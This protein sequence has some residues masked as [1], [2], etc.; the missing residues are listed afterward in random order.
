[1]ELNKEM[2]KVMLE[3]EELIGS[4]C[5]NPNSYDGW[6]N[7]EGRKFRYPISIPDE[8]GNYTKSR[9]PSLYWEVYTPDMIKYMKYKFGSNELFIGKGLINVLEFLEKRYGIDFNELE[10][11]KDE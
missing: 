9:Y 7:I 10:S 2:C 6:N 4:E 1:M 11:K 5:Y 3:L 8:K